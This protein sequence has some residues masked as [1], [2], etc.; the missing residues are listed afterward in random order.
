MSL[1]A[2]QQTYTNCD[3]ATSEIGLWREGGEGRGRGGEVRERERERG[4]IIGHITG[5]GLCRE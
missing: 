5:G 2:Q 1:F 4:I 3:M